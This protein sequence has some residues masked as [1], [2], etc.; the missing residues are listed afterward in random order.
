MIKV[1]AVVRTIFLVFIVGYTIRAMPFLFTGVPRTLDEQYSRCAS[2]LDSVQRAAWIAI[3]WVALETAIGWLMAT[4]R[5][6]PPKER[7]LPAGTP[8]FVPPAGR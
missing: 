3:A 1:L 5:P 2:G 6:R 7:P 8:P 4:R